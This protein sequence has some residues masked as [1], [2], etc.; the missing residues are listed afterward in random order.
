M[1]SKSLSVTV[2]VRDGLRVCRIICEPIVGNLSIRRNTGYSI[3]HECKKIRDVPQYQSN[4]FLYEH[5]CPVLFMPTYI[6]IRLTLT[7]CDIYIHIVHNTH[8]DVML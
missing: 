8:L 5:I 3:A 4:T 2:T 1:A 6:I 7:S